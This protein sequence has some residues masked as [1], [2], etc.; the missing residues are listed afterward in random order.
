MGNSTGE[1]HRGGG[2]AAGMME[3]TRK[4]KGFGGDRVDGREHHVGHRG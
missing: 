1:E 4:S 3:N 2:R